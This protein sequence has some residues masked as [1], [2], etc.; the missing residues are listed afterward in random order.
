MK[1]V[2]TIVAA[3]LVIIASSAQ[4]ATVGY[5]FRN[6]VAGVI[7]V[8]SNTDFSH[9]ESR[10]DHYVAAGHDVQFDHS[11]S[12]TINASTITFGL[13][14]YGDVNSTS[15]ATSDEDGTVHLLPGQT[16][17]ITVTITPWSTVDA[18]TAQGE[19]EHTMIHFSIGGSYSGGWFQRTY[20][21]TTF[22][23]N[24]G[25]SS[26]TVNMDPVIFTLN[27]GQ[28]FSV[29]MLHRV[30]GGSGKAGSPPLATTDIYIDSSAGYF[31]TLSPNAT[32][33][34]T[35][36]L[37]LVP[38]PASAALLALAALP[39]MRRRRRAGCGA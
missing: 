39:L 24:S 1:T 29:D 33:S 12:S 25:P 9:Q 31:V 34:T 5:E 28:S 7:D 21:D 36:G 27:H 4:A 32:L 35:S 8:S 15:A 26:Y 20:E 18:K 13:S 16:G 2:S 30:G 11:I 22:S 3:T 6:P 23:D 19:W 17:P 10:A 38:E 14:G 37:P